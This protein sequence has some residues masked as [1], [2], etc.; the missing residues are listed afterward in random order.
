MICEKIKISI[1]FDLRN[2]QTINVSKELSIKLL[3]KFIF[4]KA[5]FLEK[6]I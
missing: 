6:I 5:F 1:T 2:Q 3:N 4:S